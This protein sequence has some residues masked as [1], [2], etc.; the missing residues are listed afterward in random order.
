M[1][2]NQSFQPEREPF[3]DNDTLQLNNNKI[4]GPFSFLNP[5]QAHFDPVDPADPKKTSA[6]SQT[7]DELAR[8]TKDT[9]ASKDEV[10]ASSIQYKWTSRNNRKGRHTLVVHG[11]DENNAKYM[12]PPPSNSAKVVSKGIWRMFTYYPVWDVSY[13]VAMVFTWGSVIWVINAF[14]ALLPFTN[15]KSKFPGEV[16]Y[17][18]GITAFIGASV[19]EIGSILLMFEAVNENRA[20]C[21][22]W[23]LEK[24][25][26]EH[27][28]HEGGVSTRVVPS[29]DNCT[30]HHQN[31]GNFVGN[32]S[33]SAQASMADD[34]RA[35][36]ST[37]P[38]P[39]GQ[40]SW[41][42]FPSWHELKTHY[43][44]DLGFLACSWQTFGATIFWISGFTALPGIYN[45][46]KTP[47]ELNGAYWAPQVIGGFGFVVSG[48]LFMVET[49]KHWWQPA[50]G[51]LGWHIGL[52]NL[53]G[54]VGFTLCPIFGLL[55]TK[56]WMEYQAS[57][58]TFW[59]SWAF[60]IGSVV[61]LYESLEKNPVE[62]AKES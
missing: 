29:K 5:T 54:G 3:R 25:Y 43:F 20:G 44:H 13:L 26:T 57:C 55:G 46:L 1:S 11:S 27:V 22:G 60:L 35:T 42:W 50:F 10:P 32:P 49:Q 4:H 33:K 14:F 41:V 18:G 47:G 31:K 16:L 15:P 56:H 51:V 40:K 21:F 19:F 6:D 53:I 58:S 30:H 9:Q 61:Q 52:W 12:V 28:S 24:L 38:T 48:L 45:N 7:S 2:R 8:P 36:A 17:G 34:S 39:E 23:A 62:K 37:D 59:G